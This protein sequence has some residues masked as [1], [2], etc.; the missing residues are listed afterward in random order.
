MNTAKRNVSQQTATDEID[1]AGTRLDH[2]DSDYEDELVAQS[3]TPEMSEEEYE[4]EEGTDRP[5]KKAMRGVRQH[6]NI[7]P[8][9]TL[10][11][12]VDEDITSPAQ[13]QSSQGNTQTYSRGLLKPSNHTSKT[14]QLRLTFGSGDQDILPIIHARDIWSGSL[15][16]TFPSRESLQR[17][18]ERNLRGGKDIFG[19]DREM[20]DRESTAG[21]DWYYG[22][23]GNLFRGKQRLTAITEEA[24]QAYLPSCDVPK[25]TVL[26][27]PTGTQSTYLIGRGEL[28]DFGTAWPSTRPVSIKKE[29]DMPS[30]PNVNEG[31]SSKPNRVR[32]R[33]GWVLNLGNRIQCLSWA[34]NYPGSAQYLAVAVPIL[35]SQK[36]KFDDGSIKGA[37]AFTP[38]APYPSAIQIWRFEACDAVNGLR[39]PNMNIKP[40]LHMVICTDFGNINRLYWCPIAVNRDSTAGNSNET[41]K[42]LLLA[43]LWSDGSVKVLNVDLH[44]NDTGTK[45]VH[46]QNPAFQVMPPSTVCTCLTWMSP[47][48]IA[49]GCANGF[50]GLW[51]LVE[52]ARDESPP[53]PEPY[54]YIPVHDTYI[55]NIV[56]AYPTHP[57]IIAAT[58][59]GGQT[60]LV[61][62]QD[63]TAEIA[64]ALRLRVGTQCLIY[65]PYLR[66]VITNDEGDFIRLLPLRRF[67]TS[68]AAL[69]SRSSVTALATASLHHPCILAGNASGAVIANNP[70][71][72]LIHSKE[73]QWQQNWFSQEWVNGGNNNQITPGAVVK[74]YDGFKAET[75]SLSKGSSAQEKE[76]GQAA[77]IA[78][79][80]EQTAITA[81][82]WNSNALCAG[83][84]CAGMGSG[85]LRVEDL[86]HD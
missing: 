3:P 36:A 27:G 34:P 65:A 76:A 42:P 82:A 21:W 50:V 19:V 30:E 14:L 61:S 40:R 23:I 37:P 1:I 29:K 2:G 24:C 52:S 28:F 8:G 26:I 74:F 5:R 75:I 86:A 62:L 69:K 85:L 6:S 18:I 73:K 66:S 15:D 84:A 64:D 71:R 20:K 22:K 25:L 49:I 63:P 70:L 51:S 60:R 41:S 59:M 9:P 55:L 47:T 78:I 77:L 83:W 31:I 56:S 4:E 72:K 44:N 39:K 10:G 46:M 13:K 7:G 43:G 79:Y 38:S 35:D 48:D 11:S 67:F 54:L 16:L 58:S 81:V 80:E 45:Y 17:C 33:E 32:A 57:Y 53:N 12:T 68:L